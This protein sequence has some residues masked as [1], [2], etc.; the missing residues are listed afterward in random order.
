MH[1]PR[2]AHTATP[3][4]GG[5]VLIAGGCTL[6]SCEMDADGATAEV[7]ETS[8]H[9]FVTTEAMTV[10]RVGHA[11]APLPTGKVLLVGGWSSDELLAS[12]EIYDPRTGSFSLTGTMSVPRGGFTATPLENGT[13]L[14]A[15]G[16][17]GDRYLATA[18]IYDP[19]TG[20][21]TVTGRMHDARGAHVAS[22]LPDGRVL[23]AGGSEEEGTVLATAEIYDPKTGRFTRTDAMSVPRH[24]H[25]AVSLGNGTILI[26]GGSDEQDGFGRYV[27]AEIFDARK[28]TFREAPDMAAERYKITDAVVA[29]PGGGALVA[30][31]ASFAELFAPSSSSFTG[32]DGSLESSWAFATATLL[33]DGSVL[34]AGG[35]DD[36]IAL[37]AGAWLYEPAAP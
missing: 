34:I 37:T 36:E 12:A 25:A 2:A 13:V 22:R 19:R 30:G 1:V 14:I 28:E 8:S 5:G 21:F 3:L 10:E 33:A 11:A 27:S 18:E 9:S 31:G 15:G 16:T 23:V 29:L 26:V 17:D 7:Y 24:K 32:V 20:V 6:D 35:Y 4:P